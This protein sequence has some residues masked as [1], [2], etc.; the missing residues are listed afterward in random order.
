VPRSLH[1]LSDKF[2]N[3]TDRRLGRNMPAVVILES[4]GC[5]PEVFGSFRHDLP[6]RFRPALMS[7]Y[8]KFEMSAEAM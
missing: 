5:T 2:R 4:A 7:Q 1:P 3:D 6:V 8:P